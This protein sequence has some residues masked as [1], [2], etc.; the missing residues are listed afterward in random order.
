MEYLD[1]NF[2]PEYCFSSYRYFENN[3]KHINRICDD[4]VIIFMLGGVLRF[5]ENGIPIE[6]KENQYYIQKSGLLQTGDVQSEC[7]KY[8]YIHFHGRFE[9]EKGEIPIRGKFRQSDFIELFE[10][11]TFANDDITSTKLKKTSIF[12]NILDKITET[13]M[14]YESIKEQLASRV[15]HTIVTE[16]TYPFSMDNLALKFSYSK[17]YIIESFKNKYGITPYKYLI[18]FRLKKS[19]QLLISS[20]K[21]CQVIS[22]ECGFPDYSVF[23]KSFI[24]YYG[25]SPTKWRESKVEPFSKNMNFITKEASQK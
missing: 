8:F 4:D 23:Y 20:D 24:K 21:P 18:M 19:Q 10:D 3:E 16:Y 6:L 11:L 13:Q 15:L 1:C 2:T 7:P 5:T 17:N 9:N 22:G 12:Y 25:M 14:P